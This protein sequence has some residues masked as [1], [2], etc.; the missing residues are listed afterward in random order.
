[1]S[2]VLSTGCKMVNW[3]NE[4]TLIK[5][6]HSTQ[7]SPSLKSSAL[8]Y[9]SSDC[10]CHIPTHCGTSAEAFSA[11]QENPRRGFLSDLQ[12]L[13]SNQV[14]ALYLR[15]LKATRWLSPEFWSIHCNE[16]MC[17]FKILQ[18]CWSWTEREGVRYCYSTWELRAVQDSAGLCLWNAKQS[19]FSQVQLYQHSISAMQQLRCFASLPSRKQ[20]DSECA[21]GSVLVRLKD[22]PQRESEPQGEKRKKERCKNL[23]LKHQSAIFTEKSLS[24]KSEEVQGA[25]RS[26]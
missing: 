17:A 13:I 10:Y 1:M 7:F 23:S 22:A 11:H 21:C 6:N 18:I 24:V 15:S 8:H 14:H 9:F 5:I 25:L 4:S 19:H 16:S 12:E 20:I 2:S 26:M 3:L